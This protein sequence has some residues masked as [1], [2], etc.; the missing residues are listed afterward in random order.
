[1][2]RRPPRSTRT[3]TLCPYTTLFRSAFADQRLCRLF[4]PEPFAPQRRNRNQPVAAQP[5]DRG[6]EAEALHTGD[7]RIEHLAYAVRQP[8]GDIAIDGIAPG[9]HRAALGL[10]A[11]IADLLQ[12]RPVAL[13]PPCGWRDCPFWTTE[14]GGGGK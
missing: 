1:M 9:L 13:S 4:V 5:H 8:G 3:D 14:E 2:I 11:G 10:A 12:A 6:E 7:A